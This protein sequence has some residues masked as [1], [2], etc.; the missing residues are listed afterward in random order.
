MSS[1]EILGV[2]PAPHPFFA[3][4]A[5]ICKLAAAN[6]EKEPA[7]ESRDGIKGI[8]GKP[9]GTLFKAYSRNSEGFEFWPNST[10]L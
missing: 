2:S 9:D 5:K 7:G 8:S 10:G 4:V 3:T 6:G 1:A